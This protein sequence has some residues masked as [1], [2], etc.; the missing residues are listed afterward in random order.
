MCRGKRL[1]LA[2]T[3]GQ[4]PGVDMGEHDGV[5]VVAVGEVFE[6]LQASAGGAGSAIAEQDDDGTDSIL[7][8]TFGVVCG[9][10]DIDAGARQRRST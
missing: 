8:Q 6:R 9:E 1:A 7:E 2:A 4:E 5:G 3:L 10:G